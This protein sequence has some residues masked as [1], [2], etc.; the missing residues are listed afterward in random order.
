MIDNAIKIGKYM[1]SSLVQKSHK[2]AGQIKQKENEDIKMVSERKKDSKKTLKGTLTAWNK[3]E[4]SH[5]E[6]S[7]NQKHE[8][9]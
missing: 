6:S 4:E 1:L 3:G 2:Q 9:Y 5:A 8:N 7:K